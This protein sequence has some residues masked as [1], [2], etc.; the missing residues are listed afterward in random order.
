MFDEDKKA[1]TDEL[2]E[3]LA[4]LLKPSGRLVIKKSWRDDCTGDRIISVLKL[5][6]FVNVAETKDV[7]TAS[8]P[9]YASGSSLPLKLKNE[10]APRK[11]WQLD[12]DAEEELVD[13]EGLLDADDL[14]KP[15]PASLKVCGT[16]GKRK[17]CANCSCGLADELEKAEIEDIK[18]NTQNAKSSCGSVSG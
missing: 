5:S 2:G 17:A 11:V 14:K 1:I 16:T 7:V 18:K 15:D 13:E 9:N 3:C 8:K 10:G 12:D 6:G 4:H